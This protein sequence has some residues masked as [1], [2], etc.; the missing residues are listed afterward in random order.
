[1]LMAKKKSENMSK[2]A[3]EMWWIFPPGS[4]LVELVHQY[5]K[6]HTDEP[7]TNEWT[8]EPIQNES[9]RDECEKC[10]LDR[11]N[12]TRTE[13]MR[14]QSNES[15]ITVFHA[16]VM[17]NRLNLWTK[18]AMAMAI[19]KLMR[20]YTCTS[21]IILLIYLCTCWVHTRPRFNHRVCPICASVGNDWKRTMYVYMW[22]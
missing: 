14:I 11:A 7:L 18:M 6:E 13:I 8:D 20:L 9:N 2:E 16:F 5:K 10:M 12:G 22:V 17:M 3:L 1:M 21:N 19:Y 4:Q 15:S